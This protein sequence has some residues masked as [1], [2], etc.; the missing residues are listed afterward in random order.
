[1]DLARMRRE[2]EEHGLTESEADADPLVQFTGWLRVAVEAG[3]DEPNAMVLA[4]VDGDGQP[5]SRFVLL[6]GATEAGFDF[7]TNYGSSK[8]QQMLAVPRASLTFG[9]LALSRQ[10]MVAGPVAKVPAD[11][12]DAYWDLRPRGSQLGSM[13]SDQSRPIASRADLLRRY[14][15]LEAAHPGPVPRPDNWGGWRLVP[16]TIELWQGRTNR[17]HDRLRYTRPG[18]PG[19]PWTRERLNP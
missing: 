13:A 1:M 4:T 15:E 6:K 18:G 19:T 8:S 12:S 11:E 16:H 5:W 14:D 2:Y 7:Y 3:I 9:W 17:L 10:V